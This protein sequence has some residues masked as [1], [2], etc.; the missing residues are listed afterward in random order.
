VQRA[1]RQRRSVA[2]AA[3]AAEVA[4]ICEQAF[5]IPIAAAVV[6]PVMGIIG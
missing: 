3:A 1:P 2:A 5:Q 6:L 4:L